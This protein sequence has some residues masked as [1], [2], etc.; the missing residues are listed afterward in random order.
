MLFW[1]IHFHTNGITHG[2][3]FTC[4]IFVVYIFAQ[5]EGHLCW[6]QESS[7]AGLSVYLSSF[8]FKAGD[9][10]IEAGLRLLGCWRSRYR[11]FFTCV[12]VHMGICALVHMAY[13][14]TSEV[15]FPHFL[16]SQGAFYQRDALLEVFF[17]SVPKLKPWGSMRRWCLTF[18]PHLY[19]QSYIW[20][21]SVVP[22]PLSC[23]CTL[24]LTTEEWL[25]ALFRGCVELTIQGC[26][27]SALPFS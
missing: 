3:F 6:M 13:A 22:T 1:Y 19:T 20:K 14:S 7:T 25:H 10:G 11:S 5:M 17:V 27:W 12:L 2:Y 24:G 26:R 9:W 18:S 21:C 8:L 4:L 16:R 15:N 23:N